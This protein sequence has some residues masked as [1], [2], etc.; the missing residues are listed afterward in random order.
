MLLGN[1]S[2]DPRRAATEIEQGVT[3]IYAQRGSRGRPVEQCV[4]LTAFGADRAG[5]G[6]ARKT[7]GLDVTDARVGR[8]ERLLGGDDIRTAGQEVSR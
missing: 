2:F 7:S 8:N 3:E 6:E 4:E 5:Q 1:S